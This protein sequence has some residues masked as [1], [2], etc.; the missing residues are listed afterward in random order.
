MDKTRRREGSRQKAISE[1]KND[2]YGRLA[3]AGGSEGQN[4]S[5]N[6]ESGTDVRYV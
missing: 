5:A 2:H 6:Q 1:V 3:V 4:S